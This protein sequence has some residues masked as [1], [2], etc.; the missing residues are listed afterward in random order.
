MRAPLRAIRSYLGILEEEH[1]ASL[2]EAG[3]EHMRRITT[4]ATR[5]DDLITDALIYAKAVQTELTLAP[6]APGPVLRDIVESYPQF[7]A[8]HASVVIDDPFPLVLANA[9]GLTQCVSNLL[10]NAVKFVAPGVP[11][12]VR[13]WA[14]SRGAMVRIW[15]ED[16]GIGIAADQGE[17][18][19]VMFQR[20][21]KGYEGTGVG[22]ALVR[23]VIEKMRGRVGFEP[24][25]RGGTRFWLELLSAEAGSSP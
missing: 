9:A 3:R 2:D 11:L 14:E 18:V 24:A 8:P 19:F 7:Q 10:S 13:L 20:A 1:G 16:N 22:L 25:A 4:A 15:F 21:S 12:R 17:R 5:M 6:L 23:K